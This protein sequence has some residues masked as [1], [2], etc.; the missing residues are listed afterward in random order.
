MISG[1]RSLG[2]SA[3]SAEIMNALIDFTTNQGN[4]GSGQGGG[5]GGGQHRKAK[6]GQKDSNERLN[7]KS[8][9]KGDLSDIYQRLENQRE[10]I[11]QQFSSNDLANIASASALIILIRFIKIAPGLPIAPGHK[12]ILIV[13]LFIVGSQSTKGNWSGARIGFFSGVIHF[14]SGFGKYGPLGIL[15]FI[16]LG[17]IID[18]LLFVFRNPSSNIIFGLI[19]FIAGLF[20]VIS[21]IIIAWILNVPLEFYFFYLPFIASHCLFGALSAPITKQLLTRFSKHE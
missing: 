3:D 16:L 9:M 13:P 6:G 5:H 18:I 8:I 11:S 7:L 12:N 20:R 1:M 19:G 15:Q 4:Q 17:A 14:M 2:M 21:E 10:K